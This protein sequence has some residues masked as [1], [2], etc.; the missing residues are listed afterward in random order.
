MRKPLHTYEG[1]QQVD[2]GGVRT[3]AF[4]PDAKKLA[5]GGLYKATNPLG[6][7]NE[8]IVLLFDW[9]TQKVDKQLITEG[10]PGGALSRLLWLGDGTLMGLTSGTTGGFLLFWK[11]DT[12]KAFF[13]FQLPNFARDMDLHPDGIQVAIAHHDKHLRIIRLAAKPPA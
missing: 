10:I 12:E 1:G 3:L 4:S 13:R 2:Y 5:A 11:P 6:D 9:E 7:V 8:P